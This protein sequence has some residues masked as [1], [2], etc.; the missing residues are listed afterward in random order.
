M[1]NVIFQQ[2]FYY[3]MCYSG[4]PLP[5]L[6]A[7]LPT[8]I[9]IVLLIW[10]YFIFLWI[11]NFKI[12]NWHFLAKGLRAE[13]SCFETAE[14]CCDRH[15]PR[16][17]SKVRKPA[18]HHKTHQPSRIEGRSWPIRAR[19]AM[20]MTSEKEGGLIPIRSP[21]DARSYCNRQSRPNCLLFGDK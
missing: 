13:P 11:C 1:F 20:E 5:P 10:W 16:C 15:R 14:K 17:S 3:K 2:H 18:L 21:G 8:I 4:A 19:R 7:P 12:V 9:F 6:W